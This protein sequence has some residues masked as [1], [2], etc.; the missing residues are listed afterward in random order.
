MADI[1]VDRL[2]QHAG[3][4]D[5][6]L[7][8]IKED[9]SEEVRKIL[10]NPDLFY[11]IDSEFDKKIT[12]EKRSRRSIFLSLCNIWVKSPDMPLN[13]LV[14]SESSAGKSYICKNIV[15]IFPKELFVYRTKITPEAFT[16]WKNDE[17]WNW[18][19]KICYLEDISQG[20]L[21]SPTFKVM[22]S[23]GSISTIV[24]KQKAVDIIINGKPVMLL[25]TAR[26][27]PNSEILNRFQIIGLDETAGQ[28]QEVTLNQALELKNK[29]YDP[30]ITYSLKKL[31][32][33]DVSIP[34][35]VN[36]HNYITKKYNWNDLRMRRDFSRLLALI[37]NSTAL[38]Q[39]QR[40]FNN[41]G[42]LIATEQ[43][44]NIAR[45]SISHIETTTLKGLTH[46]L[47][48]AYESCLNEKTSFSAVEIYSKYPFVTLKMWYKYLDELC[49]RG[50]LT[51]NLVETE[52]S[53]KRVTKYS[54]LK[55]TTFNLP[56]F[57]ELQQYST[58]VTTNTTNTINTNVTINNKNEENNCKKCNNFIGNTYT[59]SLKEQ[60]EE[61][62]AGVEDSLNA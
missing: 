16:Y 37:K 21:D 14:S 61:V 28:T 15:K 48:R 8:L 40:E 5:K 23:E 56:D 31:K 44:Y 6:E 62:N 4:L 46:K 54:V 19:G 24:I 30:N 7:N 35:A 49:E 55:T 32:V 11:I 33:V 51:T 52:E 42:K 60:V 18:D 25:T 53:K 29:E 34:Y 41:A 43:D 36:I 2:L 47:K 59:K 12:G 1:F 9:I 39:Y 45:E 20:I 50:L 58:I 22:C 57:E 10:L 38:Y 27:N 26:T 13:T 3:I 17:E